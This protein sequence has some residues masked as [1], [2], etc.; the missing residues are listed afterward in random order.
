MALRIYCVY[1]CLQGSRVYN[2]LKCKSHL[3]Y[4]ISKLHPVSMCKFSCKKVR[5]VI[6]EVRESI[7]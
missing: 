2:N 5:L 1:S 3:G 4:D 6:R 7:W